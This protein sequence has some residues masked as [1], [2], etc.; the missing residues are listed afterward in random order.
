MKFEV[1]NM[2]FDRPAVTNLMDKETRKRLSSMGSYIRR[3]AINSIKRKGASRKAPKRQGKAYD[4]WLNEQRNKP[5]STPGS[6][7]FSH[8]T[9]PSVNI[10][11]IVYSWDGKGSVIVGMLGFN[12]NTGKP[13]PSQLEFGGDAT[14]TKNPRRRLRK[15]GGAGEIAIGRGK[16]VTTKNG[17]VMVAYA[18]LQSAKQVKLANELNKQLYGPEITRSR[19]SARPVMVPAMNK[20]IQKF[21]EAFSGRMVS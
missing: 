14:I 3:V 20:G 4:T 1:K 2:F 8:S 15:I 11:N 9:N 5:R 19:T 12:S 13:I 18:K 16:P 17:T 10:R 21:E 6:P 7:P